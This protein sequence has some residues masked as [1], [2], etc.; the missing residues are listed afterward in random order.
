MNQELA[1]KLI[2]DMEYRFLNDKVR[3]ADLENIY[4]TNEPG[5]YLPWS[6]RNKNFNNLEKKLIQKYFIDTDFFFLKD[7]R[8]YCTKN[9]VRGIKGVINATIS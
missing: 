9:T 4:F 3:Y 8:W 7:M 2:E 1:N 6:K 5:L